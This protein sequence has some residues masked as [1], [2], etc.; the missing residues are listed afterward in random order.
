MNDPSLQ[1]HYKGEWVNG[2]YDSYGTLQK[3]VN[4][5]IQVTY[6]G[7]FKHGHIHGFGK[8]EGRSNLHA[9]DKK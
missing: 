1:E 7:Q 8:L 9:D 4:R 5:E 2:L 3:I 6:T